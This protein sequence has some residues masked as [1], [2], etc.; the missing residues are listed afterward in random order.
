MM[1][2]MMP[3]GEIPMPYGV[4]VPI[5]RPNPP[6][7]GNE[8]AVALDLDGALTLAGIYDPR[9]RA[10]AKA[11]AGSDPAE[12]DRLLEILQS[13]PAPCV[14]LCAIPQDVTAYHWVSEAGLGKKCDELIQQFGQA[15]D[16][17]QRAKWFEGFIT[18]HLDRM[19][20]QEASPVAALGVFEF[21]T[22]I[23][24]SFGETEI[25]CLEAAALYA[26]SG[27][28]PWQAAGLRWLAPFVRTW[29]ASWVAARPRYRRP[30]AAARRACPILPDWLAGEGEAAR[31]R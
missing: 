8:H 10:G 21:V 28:E 16:W 20:D 18:Q 23:L 27:H 25:H 17:C 14:P 13:H 29:W 24:E 26:L 1:T 9:V 11:K 19:G 15:H 2:K 4:S 5:F 31:P 22:A 3:A 12:M 7:S 6:V 30:A